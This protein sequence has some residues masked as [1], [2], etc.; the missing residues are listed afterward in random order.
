MKRW[1]GLRLVDYDFF[2]K[3]FVLDALDPAKGWGIFADIGVADRASNPV[4][5]FLNLRVGGERP[6]PGR[7]TDSFGVGYY[8][9]GTSSVL[10]LILGP[11]SPIRNEGKAPE[12][13]AFLAMV[14]LRL[15][16]T[17]HARAMVD[18]LHELMRR[19]ALAGGQGG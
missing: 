13:R 9:L 7:S 5:W 2:D 18:R 12:D 4:R 10:R 6:L 16:R 11:N 8:D 15:D 1:T 14:H 17:A 3:Y 19:V